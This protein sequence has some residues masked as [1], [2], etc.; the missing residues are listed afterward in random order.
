M[1]SQKAQRGGEGEQQEGPLEFAVERFLN[2][3]EGKGKPDEGGDD[4]G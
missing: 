1:S 2:A 4:G 3:E